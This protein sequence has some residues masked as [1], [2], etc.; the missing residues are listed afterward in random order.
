MEKPFLNDVKVSLYDVDMNAKISIQNV[1]KVLM[2][3]SVEH[4]QATEYTVEKLMDEKRGW[5]VLNWI[6]R[7][8]KYPK[9]ADKLKVYTWAKYGSRLQ[10]TRCFSIEDENNNVIGEAVSRWA[11]LDLE[12]RHPSRFFPGMEEAYCCDMK[13]P[14]DPGRYT[15][16]KENEQNIISEK[17]I[18]VRRSETDTNGHT[19]N[20]RYVEWAVDDVP[21]DIYMGYTAEEIKVLYRKECRAGDEITV[22]TYL[23]T[24]EEGKKIIITAMSDVQGNALCKIVTSWRENS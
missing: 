7:M 22:K 23:E 6:I 13:E 15:M 16:P 24:P 20:T 19:N 17:T 5:V 21:D 9:F 12:N 10:S 14:F 18:I 8:Y 3:T 11:F 1:V 4:T 2:E